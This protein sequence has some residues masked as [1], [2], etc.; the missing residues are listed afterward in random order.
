MYWPLRLLCPNALHGSVQPFAPRHTFESMPQ[1][2]INGIC[3][4]LM[5][6]G[7]VEDGL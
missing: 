6:R 5:N 4:V 7:I 1:R 2:V 3:S